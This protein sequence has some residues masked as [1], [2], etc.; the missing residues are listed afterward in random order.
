MCNFAYVYES[1]YT[2]YIYVFEILCHLQVFCFCHICMQLKT[3][4]AK[5]FILVAPVVPHFRH[6][7][8]LSA[9][10]LFTGSGRWWGGGGE[11]GRVIIPIFTKIFQWRLFFP[12]VKTRVFLGRQPDLKARFYLCRQPILVKTE[13]KLSFYRLD[14]YWLK[15][16]LKRKR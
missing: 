11:E 10:F 6:L 7:T 4:W 8:E 1:N 14:R 16:L 15:S 13:I 3:L 12:Y 5:K 9:Q 2:K